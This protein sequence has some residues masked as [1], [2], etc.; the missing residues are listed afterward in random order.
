MNKTLGLIL[1]ISLIT[2]LPLTS[3]SQS[4]PPSEELVSTTITVTVRGKNSSHTIFCRGGVPGIAKQ[5]GDKFKFTSYAALVSSTRKKT[6]TSKKLPL[7][8]AIL[9]EGRNECREISTTP[10]VTGTPTAPIPPAP[11]VASPTATPIVAPTA[12]PL[13]G[14]F[15]NRGNVTEKGKL[16]FG[17]PSHLSGNVTAGKQ[18][19]ASFCAGCHQERIGYSYPAID[20]AIRRAPMLY[21]ES[22]ISRQQLADLVAYLNRFNP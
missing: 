13:T 9:K 15:D 8:R 18:V 2:G 12:T 19:V 17:I 1:F 16:T 10:P 21:D 22:S 6:P 14:N 7:L 11:P 5:R 3:Y 4:M 20:S